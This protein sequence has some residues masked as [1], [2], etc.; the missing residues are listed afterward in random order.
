MKILH[1]YFWKKKHKYY[2]MG[3]AIYGKIGGETAW[4]RKKNGNGKK[5]KKMKKTGKKMKKIG[6]KKGGE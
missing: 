1:L 4:L 2:T 5:M 3:G 6:K